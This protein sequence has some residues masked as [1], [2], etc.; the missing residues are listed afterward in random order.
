MDGRQVV[1]MLDTAIKRLRNEK[2]DPTEDQIEGLISITKIADGLTAEARSTKLRLYL[3]RYQ[4]ILVI[5]SA[6]IEEDI[7]LRL[8]VIH[9]LELFRKFVAA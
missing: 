6:N 5:P 9:Q 7:D 4:K 3:A 2:F 8:D 1:G